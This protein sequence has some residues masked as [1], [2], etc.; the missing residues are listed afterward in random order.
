METFK[1]NYKGEKIKATRTDY[2][3]YIAELPP[4]IGDHGVEYENKISRVDNGWRYSQTDAAHGDYFDVYLYDDGTYGWTNEMLNHIKKSEKK[5]NPNAIDQTDPVDKVCGDI[6]EVVEQFYQYE[7]R[8]ISADKVIALRKSYLDSMLR[9]LGYSS[10]DRVKKETDPNKGYLALGKV[11]SMLERYKNLATLFRQVKPGEYEVDIP[12]DMSQEE[13]AQLFLS[14]GQDMKSVNERMTAKDDLNQQM[15]G[16]LPTYGLTMRDDISSEEWELYSTNVSRTAELLLSLNYDIVPEM[17]KITLKDESK[18]DGLEL[19]DRISRVIDT[20]EFSEACNIE[21]NY[22][23]AENERF[24]EEID[25]LIDGSDRVI[26][27][28]VGASLDFLK[29]QALISR[30]ERDEYIQKYEEIERLYYSKLGIKKPEDPAQ[31]EEKVEEE[32]GIEPYD[33]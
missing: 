17:D 21:D 9:M 32:E 18:L 6:Y 30:D 33:E 29:R 26:K 2:G 3:T 13:L 31:D 27:S 10:T 28:S 1:I 12:D 19:G 4:V 8:G 11:A 15:R 20:K 5:F 16:I 14:V 22:V 7:K 23:K 25:R 24:A